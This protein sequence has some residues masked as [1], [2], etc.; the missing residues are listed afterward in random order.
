MRHLVRL[1]HSSA[2]STRAPAVTLRAARRETAARRQGGAPAAFAFALALL[3]YAAPADAGSPSGR[4]PSAQGSPRASAPLRSEQISTGW[5]RRAKQSQLARA[6][7]ASK[8]RVELYRE[9]RRLRADAGA[10]ERAILDRSSTDVVRDAH[11]LTYLAARAAEL[12]ETAARLSGPSD[13]HTIEIDEALAILARP[14]GEPE[15]ALPGASSAGLEFQ[16]PGKA[17]VLAASALLTHRPVPVD[18]D[19]HALVADRMNGSRATPPPSAP[20]IDRDARLGGQ[21]TTRSILPSVLDAVKKHGAR[22]GRQPRSV[23]AGRNNRTLAKYEGDPARNITSELGPR[24]RAARLALGKDGI[25]MDVG[26]GEGHAVRQHIA[27]GGR[28]VGIDLKDIGGSAIQREFPGRFTFYAGDVRDVAGEFDGKVDLLT[29]VYTALAYSDDPAAVT[30]RYG[31]LVKEGGL[32]FV[33]FH[34]ST[35]R[36]L[37]DRFISRGRVLT[38]ADY[39]AST[40]G[41]HEVERGS[42]W[43]MLRRGPGPVRARPTRWVDIEQGREP[44]PRVFD[45]QD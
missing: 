6:R 19:L 14:P 22:G 8:V 23:D 38:I 26:I 17:A 36:S 10:L 1:D 40:E 32:L 28:A 37:G 25:W 2:A 20:V 43:I 41:L 5:V 24:F 39:L 31:R 30:N 4:P 13:R 9:A 45:V 21:R 34:A 27:E 16:F 18:D 3:G 11:V 12:M 42:D 35:K 7:R 15:P 29:E 33:R 44:L